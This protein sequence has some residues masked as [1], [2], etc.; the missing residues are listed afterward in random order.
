MSIQCEIFDGQAIHGIIVADEGIRNEDELQ[1][2]IWG[3]HCL[4]LLTKKALDRLL[5]GDLSSLVAATISVSDWILD[6]AISSHDRIS[7]ILV[8]AHNTVLQARLDQN[9]E[10]VLLEEL[11]SPSKSILYSAHLIWDTSRRIL[12]AAGTVFGEIVVW[13]CDVSEDGT[14]GESKVLFTFT[15]HEGSIFG[16]NISPIIIGPGH[17]RTRLLASCSDDRTIRIWDLSESISINTEL[18]IINLPRETG[19]GK[20]EDQKPSVISQER[21]VASI[22]GHSSRIWR[23][24]FLVQRSSSY[25]DSSIVN[26]L[27]FGEDS[28]A[29]QWGLEFGAPHHLSESKD[30]GNQ[31]TKSVCS[32]TISRYEGRLR[33]V[34]T[35]AFHGGKHICD[36]RRRWEN[37]IIQRKANRQQPDP[38]EPH[39][40]DS[41]SSS[42]EWDLDDVYT[43][44][45]STSP[46][47]NFNTSN[48]LVASTQEEYVPAIS[49]N[50]KPAKIKKPKKL[51]KD[52]FNRY[53]FVSDD[54]FIATTTFG[55]VL[56]G[57]IDSS[58]TW[59]E[60][61]FRE[62]GNKDLR[63]YSVVEGFPELGLIILAGANGKIYSY[64]LG[65]SLE[66]V[67]SVESKVADMFKIVGRR[68]NALLVTTLASGTATLFTVE[69]TA[70]GSA[71]FRNRRLCTLPERFVVTSAG[72]SNELLV[73]GSRNGSL[74]MYDPEQLD[75]PLSVW[76]NEECT[77]G[78]AITAI[79][80]LPSTQPEKKTYFLTTGRDGRYSIFTTLNDNQI[81]P[82]HHGTPPLGPNIEGAWFTSPGGELILSGFRSKSFIVWNETL[83]HEISSV[84]CGGAH[85]S[86]AYSPLGHFIYTK[87]SKF[88][89][90]SQP[91]TSSHKIIKRGG[92]GREIKACA[93]SPDGNFFAT[94]AEDTALRIW[95]FSDSSSQLENC[96]NCLSVTQKHTAGIQHMQWHGTSYLLSSGGNEE[97]FIWAITPIPSPGIGIGIICEASCP[98]QSAEKDL[99]IMCFDVSEP[100]H[101]TLLISLAYSDSTIKIYAY[102]K[103]T[104]FEL[105]ARGRYTSSCLTQIRHLEVEDSRVRLLTA[106]T[107]GYL[108][109]WESDLEFATTATATA[110]TVLENKSVHQNAIKALDISSLS[111]NGDMLVATGGDD[112]ALAFTLFSR[113]SNS[114]RTFILRCAHAAAIT[115]LTFVPQSKNEM[116]R[117][118]SSGNDQRV[119]E[120]VVHI[121]DGDG[122][123]E[124]QKKGDV[125]TS[126][127]DVGDV[128]FFEMWGEGR[129]Q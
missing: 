56:L 3:G 115:G 111:S 13:D 21:C 101:G 63:S 14:F 123:V 92:H 100:S 45:P 40:I 120:W 54:C 84:E 62:P 38:G 76:S 82:I 7:C 19:F 35:F 69:A 28:T 53:A 81:Q 2:V 18:N 20:K 61:E 44:L 9:A 5:R 105:R 15:G 66:E 34:N 77:A 127:A 16:V 17:V 126:V 108:T 117:F 55:R 27:S 75:S 104:G 103:M 119:K 6:V 33:Q 32:R 106:A 114:S 97:F 50:G 79:I 39:E 24:K 57:Q 43:S 107:D 30:T 121:R 83:Q 125:F 99:R 25:D 93:V 116:L 102:A 8:T 65:S 91:S 88:Y 109:L 95:Q 22:M 49:T 90:H 74:A 86:Y 36:R 94:G 118:V 112:N 70:G 113:N 58:L 48:I 73:L 124:I 80:P 12:V 96:F 72:M 51:P 71:G 78:D 89:L 4:A 1:A 64:C 29:Q 31:K 129:G 60:L 128:A 110:L 11:P 37:I 46:T 47:T 85:R 122:A 10:Q 67:G 23:V 26:I 87:A 68:S 98:E 41:T 42:K 59:K 52:A